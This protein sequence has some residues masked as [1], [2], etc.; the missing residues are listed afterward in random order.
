MAVNNKTKG[1]GVFFAA[2][3]LFSFG[4]VA[5]TEYE[6]KVVFDR[7]S[8]VIAA[9]NNASPA[10]AMG[11]SF[12]KISGN[13]YE[14]AFSYYA[15]L[16]GAASYLKTLAGKAE[17]AY[18]LSPYSQKAAEYLLSENRS[19]WEFELDLNDAEKRLLKKRVKEKKNKQEAYSFV[20]HNCNTA[21]E[22]LLS[23]VNG[24][25]KYH[26]KKPFT[27]PVEYA[28]FLYQAGKI[29]KISYV[30]AP[31]QKKRPVKNILSAA[32]PSRL[33]IDTTYIEFS[34]VYQDL[35]TVSDAYNSEL[36][37]KMLS[38]R[39]DMQKG[40]PDKLDLL[41]LFSVQ[42]V[43]KYFRVG[44]ESGGVIETGIGAGISK[45]GF[46]AYAVPI[47]GVRDSGIFA[48]VKTGGL[49]RWAD[50]AKFIVSYEA[51]TDNT[52]FSAYAG[53]KIRT[54]TEIYVQY[55]HVRADKDKT[56]A[57]LAVYF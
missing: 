19:L 10:S 3:W 39:F 11:H 22:N 16:N 56:A 20:F 2:F 24:D 35:R 42:S 28:Q 32:A 51:A 31:A 8:L 25:F 26:R 23:S 36:E 55:E 43:S 45:N 5:E 41:K 27:T 9:E 15:V 14:H 49:Y 46:S 12:L 53:I 13:G 30:R 4:A 40:R 7:V 33:A 47:V 54:G 38:V 57:G 6:Q 50:K 52:R 34:P 29:K 37:T 18:V 21:L 1:G 17:G 48:G 44:W